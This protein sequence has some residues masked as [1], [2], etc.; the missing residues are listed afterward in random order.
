MYNI[1]VL[2]WFIDSYSCDKDY[3]SH[4]LRLD[5]VFDKN[6]LT[7]KRISYEYIL[8]EENELFFTKTASIGP[9]WFLVKDEIFKPDIIW[10]RIS[11]AWSFLENSLSKYEVTPS[12]YINSISNDKYQSYLT[13][14]RYQ[15]YTQ[16]LYKYLAYKHE[17]EKFDNLL[18]IKPINA[19]W[20]AW[21][22]FMTHQELIENQSKFEWLKKT[23]IVQQYIDLSWWIPWLVEW[24]H[25]L[26]VTFGWE[27]LVS[28]SIRTPAEWSLKSNLHAW[29]AVKLVSIQDIPSEVKTLCGE[30]I[31]SLPALKSEFF[32]LDFWFC[33]DENRRYLLEL[34]ASPWI[35]TFPEDRHKEQEQY[36][37]KLAQFFIS[38]LAK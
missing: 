14:S 32:W 12:F 35:I 22:Y 34:S 19:Y 38:I 8:A 9:D 21:I 16:L 4:Y 26:R 18:V 13:L 1:G 11:E 15:P 20:G 29:G 27:N 33:A 2:T 31:S 7:L 30:I 6:N 23:Y 3:L 25:D 37:D 5:K 24:T 36:F 10:N 17:Q 28:A